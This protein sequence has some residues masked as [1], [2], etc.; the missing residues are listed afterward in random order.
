MSRFTPVSCSKLRILRPSRPMTRPFR[1]VRRNVN[2][3]HRGFSRVIG[4]NA[5]NSEAQDLTR[6][7][8][9]FGLGALLCLANNSRTFMRNLIAKV[10]EQL[11]LRFFR[12][13]ACDMFR[14]H[15]HFLNGA[16]QIALATLNLAL[17]GRE[18]MLAGIEALDA[19]VDRLLTLRNAIFSCSNFLHALFVLSLSFLFHL[20][21]SSLASTTASRRMVSASA[22]ASDSTCSASS[23]AR[24]DEFATSG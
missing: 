18:L 9:G 1:C 19:A 23:Q 10:V 20:N 16:V 17:H 6:L 7:L 12:S 8:I 3:F 22:S 24:L 13:H 14:A 15:I 2:G 5:L 4:S 11:L 21:T